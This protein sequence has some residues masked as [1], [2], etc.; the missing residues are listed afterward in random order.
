M[1]AHLIASRFYSSPTALL[2]NRDAIEIMRSWEK[3]LYLEL[4]V[5]MVIRPTGPSLNSTRGLGIEKSKNLSLEQSKLQPTMVRDTTSDFEHEKKRKRRDGAFHASKKH[6]TAVVD[7][8]QEVNFQDQ[9][10]QIEEEILESQTNYNSIYTLLKYLQKDGAVGDEDVVAAVALF[11][12][13]CRLMAGGKLN[14]L[15]KTPVNEATIVQWLRDRL[16]DFEMGL[17]LMLGNEKFDKQST[18]LTVIMRL[19]KEKA[20]HLNQSEDAVWQKGL[21]GQLV[22]ILIEKDVAEETRAEFVEKYV[23]KFDDVRY[24]TFACLAYVSVSPPDWILAD[25]R[26]WPN[27]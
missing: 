2:A 14:K 3:E 5:S 6:R 10:L 23:Q 1:P 20:L 15:Q 7:S 16:H 11:R 21:L 27:P 19:V 4:D 26:Q 17:L 9:A 22:Q 13:F 8:P 12:V 25:L 18:A 24:Y